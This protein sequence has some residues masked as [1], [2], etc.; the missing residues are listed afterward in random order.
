MKFNEK[1]YVWGDSIAKGVVMDETRGRYRISKENCLTRLEKEC[2]AEIHNFAVM[3]NTSAQGLARME[4]G[5]PNEGGIAVIEFGGN[6]CD[7]DWKAASEQPDFP[8]EGKVPLKVFGE[9]LKKM[10]ACAKNAGLSP[11]LVTPPPLVSKRYFDWVSRNL[12]A[13]RIL[14]YLGD[15]EHIYRWQERYALM[16][17]NVARAENVRLLDIRD[18]FLASPRMTDLICIDGIHP[19]EKGH[20]MLYD[21][22]TAGV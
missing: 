20:A 17:R 2:G 6:D 9:N 19:N 18:A 11:M 3:G 7:L 14:E 21:I 4:A 1:I 10:I 12:S 16:I 5:M 13:E 8:Q 15:V 22:L